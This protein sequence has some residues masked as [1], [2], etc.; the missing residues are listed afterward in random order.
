MTLV[1]VHFLEPQ[2][3]RLLPICDEK[4]SSGLLKDPLFLL[5]HWG[6]ET[7]FQTEVGEKEGEGGDRREKGEDLPTESSHQL[8]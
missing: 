8:Y 2:F 6:Y 1:A 5:C 7:L 3:L 4:T